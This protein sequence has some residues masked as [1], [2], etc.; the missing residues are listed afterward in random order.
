MRTMMRRQ[1]GRGR[2]CPS[3][4]Q[5]PAGGPAKE[6]GLLVVL[7]LLKQQSGPGTQWLW[8]VLAVGVCNKVKWLCAWPLCLLLYFT[9]PNCSKPRWENW[10]MLSF[11]SSTLWI[12]GFSYIMVWMVRRDINQLYARLTTERNM[13]MLANMLADLSRAHYCLST[14]PALTALILLF[15]LPASLSLLDHALL[16]GSCT[17]IS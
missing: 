2:S 11:V 14:S 16:V 9:V 15:S 13:L 4:V 17:C 5:V 12:A 1:T 6:L 7:M 10:F 3:S 8:C